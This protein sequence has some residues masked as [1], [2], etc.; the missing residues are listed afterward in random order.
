MNTL[1]VIS[2]ILKCKQY[3]VRPKTFGTT[4]V[5]TNTFLLRQRIYDIYI[6]VAN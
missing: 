4:L 2:T 3:R 5:Y 6:I 1:S